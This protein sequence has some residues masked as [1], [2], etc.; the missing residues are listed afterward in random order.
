MA[1]AE[2]TSLLPGGNSAHGTWQHLL[3]HL[4][5]VTFIGDKIFNKI[6]TSFWDADST[7]GR[8]LSFSRDSAFGFPDSKLWGMQY[9]LL[10]YPRVMS[11][12]LCMVAFPLPFATP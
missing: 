6:N 1:T 11:A 8:V 9:I 2:F 4:S 12:L 3:S 7:P 10:I 5:G